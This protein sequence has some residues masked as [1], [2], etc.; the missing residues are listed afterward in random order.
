MRITDK[1]LTRTYLNDLSNNLENMKNLQEQLSTGKEI[2][3]P[4]DDPFKVSRSME[5]TSSITANERYESNIEEG[6]EWLK[7]TDS[8]LGQLNDVM[9]RVRELTV[10]A[11]NGTNSPTEMDSIK[12]EIVQLKD[13][14]MQAC[15]TSFNGKYI[16]GGDKT[17]TQPFTKDATTGIITYQGSDTGRK[18]EFSQ[19]VVMDVATL[20]S[21]IDDSGKQNSD[22]SEIKL[23][24]TFDNIINDL[25]NNASPGGRLDD[26]DANINNILNLRSIAGAKENRLDSMKSKN[27]DENTNLTDLLS[28]TEDVDV[29]QKYMEY[30]TAENVYTSCLKTGA[31]ILQQSLIDFL[32]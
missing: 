14:A 22:G 9:Q 10:Q 18:I 3:K 6:T 27:E 11:S 23:F 12:Q 7:T 20:G 15:N 25:G 31:K 17:I 4:S 21:N 32:S 2:N 5:L 1:M 24:D 8:T 13:E 30:N 19:G 26:L 28:Q 16:L 29:A